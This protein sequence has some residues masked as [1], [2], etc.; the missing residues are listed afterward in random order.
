MNAVCAARGCNSVV[1]SLGDEFYD[2]GADDAYTPQ[3]TPARLQ[4]SCGGPS[5]PI[6]SAARAR[7]PP[8]A[9][10]LPTSA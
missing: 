10:L 2:C 6:P 9:L 3:G 8:V 4:A 7:C 5:A 1:V